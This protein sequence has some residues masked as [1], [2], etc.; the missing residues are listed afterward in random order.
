M[1]DK[2]IKIT[3]VVLNY[4][5]ARRTVKNVKSIFSQ[6]INFH[7]KVF[8]I[9]NT[10]HK[11]DEGE[12]L[13]KELSGLENLEI[14]INK[15][16]IGYS[17]GNNIVKGR[18]EGD[19]VFV[20]NP[21]IIF[22]DSDS[23]QK[24]VDYMDANPDIAILGPQQ[25]N[26]DG[27]I[28]MSVRA[29]PKF[30][31]QVARRTFLRNLPILK[32]KV[33]Y[34]EMRHLDYSKIQDVDWLQSSCFVVRRDFWEKVGGLNEEYFLFMTDAQMCFDAWNMGYRVVYYPEVKVYADG[35]RVSDGGFLKFFRSWVL[36]AH[37]LDALKYQFKNFWLEN[38]RKK[39]YQN[40][41]NK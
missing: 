15:T 30:Y 31:L 19:Y 25:I 26:D 28:T 39:Y 29:F 21:D 17:R 40:K 16:N 32:E 13:K 20:V 35:R 7:F 3:I 27:G 9:E 38:P 33:A 8:V 12:L 41:K 18:E 6:K 5:K 24:I 23:L 10:A 14:I 22:K 11:K 2:K 37:V 36:R 34:D 1:E 4:Q